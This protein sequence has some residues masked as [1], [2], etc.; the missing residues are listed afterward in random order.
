MPTESERLVEAI[1]RLINAKLRVLQ[2]EIEAHAKRGAFGGPFLWHRATT[3]GFSE[4]KALTA[5]IERMLDLPLPAGG[6][7]R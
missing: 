3:A 2:E 7:T 6:T 1:E 5:E 4:K